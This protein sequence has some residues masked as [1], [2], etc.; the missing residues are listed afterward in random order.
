MAHTN[1]YID[2]SLPFSLA[3][4]AAVTGNPVL[5]IGYQCRDSRPY[6]VFTNESMPTLTLYTTLAPSKAT[7]ATAV[8][9]YSI[10]SAGING[11]TEDTMMLLT[12]GTQTG[13][14]LVSESFLGFEFTN[15]GN[16]HIDYRLNNINKWAK[17]K[18]QGGIDKLSPITEDERKA[19]SYPYGLKMAE[20]SSVEELHAATYEYAGVPGSGDI[21]RLTD[22][23]GYNHEAALDLS[24]DITVEDAIISVTFKSN[25]TEGSLTFEEIA[26]AFANNSLDNM[27]PAVLLSFS[28]DE[29]K[30]Y[31]SHALAK[32]LINGEFNSFGTI[33]TYTADIADYL[34]SDSD[35]VTM[36]ATVCFIV[37]PLKDILDEVKW[38]I[39]EVS[40]TTSEVTPLP[41]AMGIEM[42]VEVPTIVAVLTNA[43]DSSD[44]HYFESCEDAATYTK[45]NSTTNF[46]LTIKRGEVP[47]SCFKG[48]TNLIT[49]T[50][51]EGVTSIGD[52][53]FS[54][55]TFTGSLVIP[56][57]VIS[58]GDYAF[59]GCMLFTGLTISS[60]VTSIGDYAFGSCM[61]ITG[62]LVIPAS[63]T[64]IGDN[65][66]S[67]CSGFDDD[68]SYEGLSNPSVY[69][70]V[71][72]LSSFTKCTVPE[73]YADDNFCG[74]PVGESY[75]I[76]S[77]SAL[78]FG[79]STSQLSFTLNSSSAWKLASSVS[80]FSVSPSSGSAG[81]TTVTVTCS[82]SA[83]SA[84]SA[85][86]TF[87]ND[88]GEEATLT[89]SYSARNYIKVQ[90]SYV[91]FETADVT[92]IKTVVTST[93]AWTRSFSGTGITCSPTSGDSGDTT[94]T[95]TRT[96]DS[97]TSG[98]VIFTFTNSEGASTTITVAYANVS[99]GTIL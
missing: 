66:F 55:C 80:G 96:A 48:L 11:L 82:I 94:I 1:T 33:G 58:I 16:A 71:F 42:E 19:A 74:L 77:S 68:L 29:G 76:L 43:D 14:T 34:K 54:M 73:G 2:G 31:S 45:E 72:Y 53:A 37:E 56:D 17:Y 7:T 5:D 4:V 38:S 36:K 59:R 69:T 41:G 44:V 99:S 10:H 93:S 9:I 49:L 35:T 57:G 40:A 78:A 79:S 52:Y 70:N 47:D 64:Y 51:N 25:P 12:T 46:E 97:T 61:N 90:S 95:F 27:Y 21:A 92:E 87:T 91:S 26:A 86:L 20:I 28:E 89:L 30:T 63:V 85:T 15:A 83:S 32:L 13:S 81:T 62:S 39:T 65:A 67:Y 3:R 50:L 24:A 22:F 60:T 8:D 75:L 98:S 88:D 23:A 6:Y 84:G 18:P